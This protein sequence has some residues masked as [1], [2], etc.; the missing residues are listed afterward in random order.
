VP[1]LAWLLFAESTGTGA[2]PHAGALS[3]ILLV[4]AGPVTSV[5]LI[6]FTLAARRIPLSVVGIL[7]YIAPTMQFL[8]GV[9]VY[10]EPFTR[11]RLIGF[12]IVWLALIVYTV[13][14]ISVYRAR[15][16]PL[17]RKSPAGS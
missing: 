2:F 15:H 1:A 7:Q 8:L 6:L 11:T 10:H 5:P 16:R 3:A 12:G 14:G 17:A 13:E 9:L 4:G